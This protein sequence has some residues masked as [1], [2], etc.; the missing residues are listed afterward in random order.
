MLPP[1]G[2]GGVN[3]RASGPGCIRGAH[4]RGQHAGHVVGREVGD[5]PDLASRRLQINAERPH[6]RAARGGIRQGTAPAPTILAEDS[7][8]EHP[9]HS[10]GRADLDLPIVQRLRAAEGIDVLVLFVPIPMCRP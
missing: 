3:E 2:P 10:V 5:K 8:I 1:G 6:S 9:D 7:R 4:R